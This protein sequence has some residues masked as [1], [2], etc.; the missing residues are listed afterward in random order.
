LERFPL[1][2]TAETRTAEIDLADELTEGEA[3]R[4]TDE[5][6][7]DAHALWIRMVALYDG[8]AH[9]T[10]G[11]R[12]WASYCEAEFGIGRSR[13][14]QML[15]AGRV[16]AV[17]Q[18]T[19]GG[20]APPIN[21]RV[22]RE[23]L[24]ILKADPQNAPQRLAEVLDRTGPDQRCPVVVITNGTRTRFSRGKCASAER[25]IPR[26]W[27]GATMSFGN[28]TPTQPPRPT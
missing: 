9:F 7:R 24:P 3:R 4:L 18:S 11:Y 21:E 14:Y 8:H 23:L 27:H 17:L 19:N 22:A 13:A 12:N 20:P 1:D 28:G 2:S 26:T 15:D 6:K 16:A 25:L 5:F 10:L